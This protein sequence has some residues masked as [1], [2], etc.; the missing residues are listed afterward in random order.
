MDTITTKLEDL[1]AMI[2][3]MECKPGCHQCCGPTLWSRAEYETIKHF[4]ENNG[5]KELEATGL[6]CPYLDNEK[7][8]SIYPVRPLLCRLFGVTEGLECPEVEVQVKVS[9][10]DGYAILFAKQSSPLKGEEG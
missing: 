5:R 2:P 7:G 4:L 8:C 1:W 3:K 10:T 6:S 9:S